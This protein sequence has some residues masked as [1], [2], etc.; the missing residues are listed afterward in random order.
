MSLINDVIFQATR[1]LFIVLLKILANFRVYG[2]KNLPKNGPFI[3]ASNHVSYV[4]PGVVAIACDGCRIS[5]MA[6]R[7]LCE[8][9]TW[10]WWF[11]AMDSI[12][13]DRTSR[14]FRSLK[15]AMKKLKNGGIVGIFP[16]GTRSL[17]GE[18]KNAEPGIGLLAEKSGAPIIP[19]YLEGTSDV[20]PRGARFL[21]MHPIVARIGKAV[22]LDEA[23]S[24]H[25][26]KAR[27][28][29]IGEKVMQAIKSLRNEE[30]Y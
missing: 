13:A 21:R 15:I 16:E 25:E 17:D 28:Y 10:N 29:H 23:K 8:S 20:L 2:R 11:N 26:K 3:V 18:L 14:N 5:F 19:I 30:G 24:I 12:P 4:D 6:K 27:Y 1:C 7:E 22:N 9:R